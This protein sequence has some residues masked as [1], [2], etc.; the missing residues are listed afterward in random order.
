METIKTIL[1]V[2]PIIFAK[3]MKQMNGMLT[4]VKIIVGL[5]VSGGVAMASAVIWVNHKTEQ[6]D[7]T[8]LKVAVLEKENA[9]R[10]KEWTMWRQEMDRTIV[11]M[12]TTQETQ[13][14]LMER[15]TDRM[16][17]RP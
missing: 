6:I 2:D 17:R 1:S 16:D 9:D 11:R 7:S 3:W 13:Q 4:L 14:K 5:L 10:L 15:L 8:Q 12:V